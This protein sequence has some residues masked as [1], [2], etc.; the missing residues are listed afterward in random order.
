MHKDRLT[1]KEASNAGVKASNR[2][3][4]SSAYSSKFESEC[5]R[6][7]IAC[8]DDVCVKTD[9]QKDVVSLM[10]VVE[11]VAEDTWD[12]KREENG[13]VEARSEAGMDT[14]SSIMEKFD[15]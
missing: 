13:P 15:S 7:N 8:E 11:A 12:M 10:I 5:D 2:R 1:D 9:L 6:Y 3:A 14:G 4:D